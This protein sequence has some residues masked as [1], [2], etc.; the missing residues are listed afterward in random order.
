MFLLFWE[1]GSLSKHQANT[2]GQHTAQVVGFKTSD[3]S[4]VINKGLSGT[5]VV[6]LENGL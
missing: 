3:R 5:Q 4:E 2:V 6:T 1:A